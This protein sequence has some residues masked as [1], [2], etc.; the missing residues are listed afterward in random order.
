MVYRENLKVINQS[1]EETYED[2]DFEET[3][4]DW[5]DEIYDD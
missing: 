3:N 1:F 4:V 5:E 2:W